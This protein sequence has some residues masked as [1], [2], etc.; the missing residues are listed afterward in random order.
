MP[1]SDVTPSIASFGRDAN[2]ADIAAALHRDGA[3]IVRE[4]VEPKR[5]DALAAKFVPELE[6]Q[7]A[8]GA[9]FFGSPTR[10][11]G[12]DLFRL[13]PEVVE[14]LLLHP[15]VLEVAD[16]VLLP[17][18]PMAPANA[19]AHAS[20]SWEE[21]LEAAMDEYEQMADRD[22]V[23]GPNCHHYRLNVGYARQVCRGDT[24]QFLHREMDTF[25][26]FIEHDPNAFELILA[27]AWAVSDFTIENGATRLVPGSHR[28]AKGRE[29]ADDEVVQAVMPKGSVAL[30]TGRTL[31]GL[32]ASNDES[33]TSLLFTI[34]ANWLTTEENQFFAVPP[35]VAKC[36]S[37]RGQQII[38]YRGSPSLGWVSGRDPDNLLEETG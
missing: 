6:A 29:A 34:L 38:G 5:M 11:L 32:A 23:L 24:H 14:Q 33:R 13:A 2:T 9:E 36:L 26:P 7:S 18:A 37:P 16:A 1:G 27:M 22:P 28:W 17:Q 20:K 8:G 3:V 12:G 15:T 4:L 35:E 10:G 30:W 21:G 19:G 25:R 31:H